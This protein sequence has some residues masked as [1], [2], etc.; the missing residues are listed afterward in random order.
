M[1]FGED[2]SSGI[3]DLTEHSYNYASLGSTSFKLKLTCQNDF[4]GIV[5]SL[6]RNAHSEIYGWNHMCFF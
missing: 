4:S 1:F 2:T 6:V 3:M 5:M